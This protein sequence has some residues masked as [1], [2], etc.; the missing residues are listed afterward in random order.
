MNV[1]RKIVVPIL[2]LT[3]FASAPLILLY[4]SGYS[5]NLKRNRL[6]KSGILKI[7][8]VPDGAIVSLDGKPGRR[9]T[10]PVSIGHLM[11]EQY[12]VSIDRPGFLP[13]SK[14]LTVESGKTTFAKGVVLVAETLPQMVSRTTAK[15]SALDLNGTTAA[16]L[17]NDGQW[18]EIKRFKVETESVLPLA[19][20]AV[21]RYDDVR[22]SLSD[23]GQRLLIGGREADGRLSL[24]VY[25]TDLTSDPNQLDLQVG[26]S[27]SRPLVSW[28]AGGHGLAIANGHELTLLPSEGEIV[29]VTLDAA[30]SG[31][32]LAGDAIWLLTE[33]RGDTGLLT[34][35]GL[36]DLKPAGQE[37]PLPHSGMSLVGGNDRYLVL[38]GN[39][40]D[41]G[42]LVDT[43]RDRISRL[44]KSDG[45]AWEHADSTGRLLLWNDFEIHVVNPE[46]GESYLVTRL[47]TPITGCR[48]FPLGT[49][50]IFATDRR[51]TA[52][53]L[54]DRDRRNTF[55]L[56]S[57]E[58]VSSMTVDEQ[59]GVLH[60]V[61]A[62]GSQRGIYER[63]L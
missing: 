57:F 42:L 32:F 26:P 52:I 58:S 33:D 39:E 53:E 18:E 62:I 49:M 63:P 60:F 16:Y 29:S 8:T 56:A 2:L 47:G 30:P 24:Q 13:W 5:Y 6:E 14:T 23:D 45:L 22:L 61:G 37:I 36:R 46:N 4:A 28:S 25:R 11:P 20:F 41:S 31:I 50:V 59:A 19:R 54:D 38:T 35:I 51:I 9:R 12:L 10:T 48:W 55:I 34:R 44:P 43:G 3:F 27:E 7:D 1:R 21:G 15:V 17:E 40:P